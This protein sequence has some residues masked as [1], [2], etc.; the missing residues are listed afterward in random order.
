VKYDTQYG[1]RFGFINSLI[2]HISE[3]KYHYVFPFKNGFA[4]VKLQDKWGFIN[5]KFEE[6]FGGCEFLKV[7]DFD[8]EGYA[9][10]LCEDSSQPL[11]EI[12]KYLDKNGDLHNKKGVYYANHL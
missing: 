11:G 10:V 12:Y 2:D 7:S 9:L 4:R 8:N 6:V 1:A 5:E 3:I